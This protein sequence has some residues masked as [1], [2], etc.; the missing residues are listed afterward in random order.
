MK[1]RFFLSFL[2]LLLF[3]STPGA[4]FPKSAGVISIKGPISPPQAQYVKRALEENQEKVDFFILTLDT[5]GGLDP[6]MREI[7]KAILSSRK[8]VVGYVFPRGARAASAGTFIMAACHIDAM[9]P[10]T[11]MGAAHPVMMGIGEGKSKKEKGESVLEK[12]VLEDAVSYIRSLAKMR[13]RNVKSYVMAVKEAKSFDPE[14][15]LKK[16]MVEMVAED[17]NDLLKKL[18]GRS[19]KTGGKIYTFHTKGCTIINIKPSARERFLMILGNPNIAY[20]LLMLGFYGIFFEL[21]SPGAVFPGVIGGIFLILGLY[22]MHVLPVNYA[23]VFLLLLS[24]ILFLLEIKIPS[25]GALTMGGI[26][27]FV[28]GSLFLIKNPYP[29][30]RVSMGVIGASLAFTLLFFLVIVKKG[31][32]AL[33]K[34]PVSG[35]EGLVGEEGL[36]I[37]AID[38]KGGKVFIHGEIWNAE[39]PSPIDK[40][41]KVEVIEVRGLLLRVKKKEGGEQN[42]VLS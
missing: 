26:V 19:I 18:N 15:A 27:S 21:T 12:K 9:A 31:V 22:S 35:K 32:S 23:G 40:G 20:M 34:K 42:G 13:G 36:A 25:H 17:I 5:P 29:Y 33:R 14:E 28:T 3:T 30:L 11:S 10:G 37:T 16:G 8:P 6:S 38:G 39:S 24:F 2:L 1:R 41:E 7:I 4:S